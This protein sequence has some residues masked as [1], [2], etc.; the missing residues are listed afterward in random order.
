LVKIGALVDDIRNILQKNIIE[1][2]QPIEVSQKF[3]IATFWGMVAAAALVVVSLDYAQPTMWMGAPL[4]P[5]G[6]SIVVSWLPQSFQS[7]MLGVFPRA[8][9]VG[10]AATGYVAYWVL[11]GLFRRVRKWKYYW[12]CFATLLCLLFINVAGCHE[13]LRQSSS[14]LSS[15][16]GP[17]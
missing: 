9:I 1:Q 7:W 5:M 17:Q 12:V 2:R 6:L 8:Y 13:M 11:H 3:G 4:F 16:H 15:I 14:K 10:V